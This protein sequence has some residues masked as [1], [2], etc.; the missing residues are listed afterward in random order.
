MKKPPDLAQELSE[1][2]D[3]QVRFSEVDSMRV[4]WHGNYFKYFE[5]GR[6]AFGRKYGIGYFDVEAQQ[7]QVPVVHSDIDYKRALR[8]GEHIRVKVRFEDTPAA[9]IIFHYSIHRIE[10]EALIAVGKTIQ[11]FT[12]TE[13]ELQLLLPDFFKQWKDRFLK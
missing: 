4:V 2:I 6:E 11:V 5:D 3:L 7:L 9:K 10:D 8:Y 12:N 13:G 1:T